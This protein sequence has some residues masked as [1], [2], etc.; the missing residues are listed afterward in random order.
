[1]PSITS[2]VRRFTNQ[3]LVY[4]PKI[5]SGL[6]GRP[7]FGDPYEIAC[8]WEDVQKEIIL[9]DGRIVLSKGYLLLAN[10]VAV[11]GLVFLGKLSD[12]AAMPTY[13]A[14]PT[15]NQGVREV[16]KFNSTPDL[17]AQGFVNEAF[18]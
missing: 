1:M 7:E 6:G 12:W 10:P 11:G 16:I 5:D 2:V 8:R 15:V 9:P 4:W 13:P 17:K 3:I 18:I 14:I